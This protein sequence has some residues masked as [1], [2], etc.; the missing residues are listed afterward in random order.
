M[1]KTILIFGINML[2]AWLTPSLLE[3]VVKSSP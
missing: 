1:I 2:Y 3:S